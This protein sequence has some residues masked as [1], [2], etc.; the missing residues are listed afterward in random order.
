[1]HTHTHKVIDRECS[2]ETRTFVVLVAS[3]GSRLKTEHM[4]KPWNNESAEKWWACA[5]AIACAPEGARSEREGAPPPGG[6][7]RKGSVGLV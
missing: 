2:E 4:G 5:A 6:T 7:R 3:F 1:M